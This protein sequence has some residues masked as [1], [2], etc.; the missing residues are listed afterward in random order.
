MSRPTPPP[1]TEPELVQ[2]ARTLAGRSLAQVATSFGA[3]LPV[4]LRRHKG[5]VGQLLEEVLGASAGSR[6]EPDFPGLGVELKTIP[7]R[8]DGTVRESTFVCTAPLDGSLDVAWE[9]SWVRRKLS[10]VLWV[11][12]IGTGDEPVGERRVGGAVL[13]SPSPDEDA[14]LR[15]DWV[16][17]ADRLALGELGSLHAGHGVALQLRPKGASADDVTWMLGEEGEWVRENP[18]GFYL[19]A[20]FTEGILRARLRV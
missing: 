9:Q 18:R 16:D 2:R 13:W 3:T 20:R 4:D 15:A 17:L 5:F 1:H 10:R 19:R 7:V 6:A 14:V 8:P 12:V 11:P